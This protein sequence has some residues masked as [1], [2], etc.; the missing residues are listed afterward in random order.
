MPWTKQAL[1]VPP[2][3]VSHLGVLA[4]PKMSQAA[5]KYS[6]PRASHPQNAFQAWMEGRDTG[7]ETEQAELIFKCPKPRLDL[8]GRDGPLPSF[9]PTI[10]TGVKFPGGRGR[11][12]HK[13]M[14]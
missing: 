10:P 4:T 2:E 14:P 3:A 7:Y 11:E 9:V 13:T 12:R 5:V 1:S 8:L 6:H